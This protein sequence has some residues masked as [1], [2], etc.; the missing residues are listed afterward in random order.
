MIKERQ[1]VKVGCPEEIAWRNGWI[2]DS[3]L[4]EAAGALQRSGY[5]SYLLSILGR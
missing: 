2:D 4:T 3:Q 1:G 5:G